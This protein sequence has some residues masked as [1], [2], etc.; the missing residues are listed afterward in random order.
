VKEEMELDMPG[1]NVAVPPGANSAFYLGDRWLLSFVLL[2][3]LSW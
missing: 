2:L 1:I 3:L